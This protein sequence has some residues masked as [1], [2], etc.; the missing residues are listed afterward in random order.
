MRFAF[1]S[2]GKLFLKTTDSAPRPLD[3]AFAA[4]RAERER[5]RAERHAWKGAGRD[6]Q[7]T[8]NARA[9]WGRQSAA[10]A[11]DDGAPVYRHL[12]SGARPGELLY[13]LEMSASSGLFRYDVE[14]GEE[15]RVFHRQEFFCGG[16]SCHPESGEIVYSAADGSGLANLERHAADRSR[17]RSLTDGEARDSHPAHDLGKPGALVFQSAG[18]GRDGEGRLLAFGP[19]AVLRF[20]PDAR[21]LETLAESDHH[22]HLSPRTDRRG[23][24]FFIRRPYQ[25]SARPGLLAQAK[26]FVLLPYHLCQAVFGFMDAFTRIFGK[27]SLRPAGGPETKRPPARR[28]VQIH[29]TAVELEQ[30][31]RKHERGDDSASLVPATWELVRRSPSGEE[32]ALARGVASFTLGRDDSVLYTNGFTVWHLAPDASDAR[33]VHRGK[34]IQALAIV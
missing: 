22:D 28:W 1:L 15:H 8:F 6:P 20:D 31:L 30:C 3:S 33:V 18:A 4:D 24:L 29:E 23:N 19:A 34:V 14:T 16:L 7:E 26:S 10:T 27:T 21:D 2:D 17:D 13:V 12:A 9:V 11:P 5:E 32:T 25:D